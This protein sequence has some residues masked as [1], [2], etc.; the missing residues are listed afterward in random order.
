[1]A[2]MERSYIVSAIIVIALLVV[3]A[4]IA[5]S[6]YPDFYTEITKIS[7]D[8]FGIVP[9]EDQ[10]TLDAQANFVSSI[11]SCL[12]TDYVRCGCKLKSRDLPE[13]YYMMVRNTN[14]GVVI[15]LL[16]NEDAIIGTPKLIPNAKIGIALH[17]YDSRKS[18]FSDSNVNALDGVCLFDKDIKL[19]GNSDN[20]ISTAIGKEAGKFYADTD[21]SFRTLPELHK[22]SGKSVCIITTDLEQ[23]D[24]AEMQPFNLEVVT[25][26]E[27]KELIYPVS[28]IVKSGRFHSGKES[29]FSSWASDLILRLG[30]REIAPGTADQ[31]VFDNFEDASRLT[32]AYLQSAGLCSD[33]S[34]YSWPVDVSSSKVSSCSLEKG[35]LNYAADSYVLETVSGSDVNAQAN[36]EVS[37]VCADCAE[38]WIELKYT[39]QLPVGKAY[40]KFRYSG[41]TEIKEGLIAGVRVRKGDSIGKSSGNV[42]LT[43]TDLR[44]NGVDPGCLFASLTSPHYSELCSCPT[45]SGDLS[46]PCSRDSNSYFRNCW[47]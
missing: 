17:A 23:A 42:K 22:V 36:S 32:N 33:A 4:L 28:E 44:N 9:E 2:E 18:T 27:K 7:N 6:F 45:G 3:I 31:P 43:V 34:Q 10:K 12:S 29:D 19:K 1:M 8:V 5:L 13:N 20:V 14:G 47:F 11:E 41:L 46:E 37:G 38:K 30:L 39:R 21:S 24:F 26:V 35:S 40:F 16:S 25:N 15:S